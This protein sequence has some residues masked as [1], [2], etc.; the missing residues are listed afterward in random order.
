MNNFP[1]STSALFRRKSS[2]FAKG[3]HCGMVYPFLYPHDFVEKN[4][5]AER[6]LHIL[7][8]LFITFFNI[9][10]PI[11]SG[12]RYGSC[13]QQA[14]LRLVSFSPPAISPAAN[15]PLAKSPPPAEIRPTL[16]YWPDYDDNL[17][18]LRKDVT[19]VTT[20]IDMCPS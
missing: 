7:F 15:G 13:W 16:T 19:L 11:P 14:S 12:D 20:L 2:L 4:A 10:Y 18:C 5:R 1:A 6:R 8:N 3:I 9:F 17:P